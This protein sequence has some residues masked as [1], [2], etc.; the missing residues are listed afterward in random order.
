MHTKYLKLCMV[1]NL[2][3]VSPS[4]A[5]LLFLPLED[6]SSAESPL[7]I[8]PLFGSIR[9]G[10]PGKPL[11]QKGFGGIQEGGRQLL[12][13]QEPSREAAGHW[14]EQQQALSPK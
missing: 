13:H 2:E 4:V 7:D 1:C 9:K 6:D 3:Q 11:L 14:Q 8:R 10:T 12:A 5:S